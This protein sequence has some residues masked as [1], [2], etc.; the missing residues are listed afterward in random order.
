[1]SLFTSYSMFSTK[2]NTTSIVALD[3][4]TLYL[5]KESI[6]QFT[7]PSRSTCGFSKESIILFNAKA[8]LQ[9]ADLTLS[10]LARIPTSIKT[11]C[12]VGSKDL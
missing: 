5:D 1:M 4:M 12:C 10:H 3:Y 6:L 9:I 2:A 8:G 7:M 11:A